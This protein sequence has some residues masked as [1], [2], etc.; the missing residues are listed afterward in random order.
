M[1]IAIIT[2]VF[3][4]KIDG[5]VNRTVHLIRQLVRA[6]D[7]VLVVCPEAKG[8]DQCPVP[9]VGVPSF[10]FRPYPEYRI[11]LPGPR[12]AAAVRRFA[13]EVVHYVN[14]FAFGF[15]CH[16]ALWRARVRPPSVF[17]FHTLYGEFVKRYKGLNTSCPD[18][19]GG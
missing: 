5:V 2:E 10:S 12:A 14:P 11:G 8:C 3:L 7:D 18:C 1:R 9:V 15:R 16:D 6:G 19:S 17:S 4:P 13:P